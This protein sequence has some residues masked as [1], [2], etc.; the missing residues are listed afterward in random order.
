[1]KI[2]KVIDYFGDVVGESSSEVIAARIAA[3]YYLAIIVVIH[4][5]L[6]S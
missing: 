5:G 2:Y 3:A 4:R 1:M 6:E